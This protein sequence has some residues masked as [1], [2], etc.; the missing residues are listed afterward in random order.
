MS[1]NTIK[2]I[3]NFCKK[4]TKICSRN[5]KIVDER[6][7]KIYLK[8]AGYS[9]LKGDLFKIWKE[10]DEIS[11]ITMVFPGHKSYLNAN[12]IFVRYSIFLHGSKDLKKFIE[13]NGHSFDDFDIVLETQRPSVVSISR[14]STLKSPGSISRRS[15]LNYSPRSSDSSMRR[16]ST[17]K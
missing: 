14:R 2:D 4:Y 11:A 5:K 13:E 7:A 16:R 15:T 12:D 3:D 8:D 6:R 1:F 9:V 17:L 10:L